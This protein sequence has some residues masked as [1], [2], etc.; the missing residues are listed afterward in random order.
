MSN[1]T[2]V[3]TLPEEN[4]PAQPSAYGE[5]AGA[6]LEGGDSGELSMPF[7]QVLQ[8]GSPVVKDAD[9]PE[10][11]AGKLYNSVTN[12]VSDEFY[13]IPCFRGPYIC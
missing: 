5:L 3:V 4:L 11:V 12:E 1:D 2:V 7:I 13:F 10:C 8:S 9:R 6:G